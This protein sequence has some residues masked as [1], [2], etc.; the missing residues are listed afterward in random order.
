MANKII[1]LV[2][3]SNKGIEPISNLLLDS[4][5]PKIIESKLGEYQGVDFPANYLYFELKRKRIWSGC[6]VYIVTRPSDNPIKEE[7]IKE[8]KKIFDND[9]RDF[10][11]VRLEQLV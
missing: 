6:K 4:K 2:G 1:Y 11:M 10:R 9:G 3:V 7:E 5:V 8:V